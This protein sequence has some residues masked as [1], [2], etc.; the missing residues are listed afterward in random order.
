MKTNWLVILFVFISTSAFN[1]GSSF[2]FNSSSLEL[3]LKRVEKSKNATILVY[4][5]TLNSAEKIKRLIITPNISGENVDSNV[6]FAFDENTHQA[7]LYYFY[8][9]PKHLNTFDNLEISFEL[10]TETKKTTSTEKVNLMN[11]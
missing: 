11:L 8:V 9:V 6:N 10:E 1:L 3:D 5:V 4:S 7:T 2:H